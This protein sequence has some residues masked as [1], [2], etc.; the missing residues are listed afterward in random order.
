MTGR[1]PGRRG[2]RCACCSS[3]SRAGNAARA[4]S[5]IGSTAKSS[6]E[7]VQGA[8]DGRGRR[9]RPRCVAAAVRWPPTPERRADV[10]GDRA[11]VGAASSSAA[12]CDVEHVEAR[13]G[14]SCDGELV[15]RDRSRLQLDL[16]AVAH[17]LVGAL[18]VDLD[19]RDRGRHLVDVAH[20]RSANAPRTRSRR[21]PRAGAVATTSP[22]ASSVVVETPSRTVASYAFSVSIRWPEQPGGPVDPEHQHAGGHRVEGAGVPDLAGA[23][24]PAHPGDDVVRGHPARACRRRPDRGHR[25]G[26]HSSGSSSSAASSSSSADSSRGFLYGSASPA[27]VAP[28]CGGDRVVLRLGAGEHLVEVAGGLRQGVVDEGQRR[29]RAHAELLGDLGAQQP[30]GRLERGRG[31]G[32]LGLLVGAGPPARCRRSSPAGCRR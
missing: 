18:A 25:R 22:S 28:R 13:C 2:R 16:L 21:G 3:R 8:G 10:A 27:Y 26:A 1:A 17:P 14:R 23:G 7:L 32:Q 15:D 20:D 19:R 31:A 9:A 5:A 12:R 30:L 24:Q 6:A 29:R 4:A 11:H